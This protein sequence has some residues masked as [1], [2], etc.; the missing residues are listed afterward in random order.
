MAK[1]VSY[2]YYHKPNKYKAAQA[3][4]FYAAQK[5]Y[6]PII[7]QEAR[8]TVSLK[9]NSSLQGCQKGESMMT[10]SRSDWATYTLL[11]QISEQ[12]GCF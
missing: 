10:F 11:L 12:V 7:G 5:N 1:A 6:I 9:G 4:C 3:E 8:T 2:N